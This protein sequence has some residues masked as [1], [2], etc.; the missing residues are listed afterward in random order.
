[1]KSIKPSNKHRI[2]RN[3]LFLYIRMIF[4]M[5]V[6]LYTS[7]VILRTLGFED[8]GIYDVVA[9]V[10]TMLS[11]VTASLGGASSRFITY[12]LGKDNVKESKT[13][14]ATILYIHIV[15]AIFVFIIGET[16][17][18]W[19]VY[20]KLVIPIERFE[21]SLYVYHCSIF[22]TMIHIISIPYNSLIIAYERMNIFAYI[23]IIE[24]I[25]KLVVV[26][27]LLVLP[28]DRLETYAIL[29]LIVQILIRMIYS[30]YCNKNLVISKV[31]PKKDVGLI[32]NMLSYTSWTLASGIA[33]VGYTQGLNILLNMFFGPV[34]NAARGISVQVQNAIFSFTSNIQTAMRPQIIKNFAAGNIGEMHKLVVMSSNLGFIL[35]LLL[36][37]PIIICINPILTIWLEK[38]PKHTA[39]FV[40][41]MLLSGLIEPYKVTLLNAI[42]ATGKIRKFQ[43]SE[44]IFLLLILPIS[45]I[46]LKCYNVSPEYVFLIYLIIQFITQIVRVIIILPEMDMS[47]GY[48][49]KKILLPLL[50]ISPCIVS[51]LYFIKVSNSTDFL[52]LL[53][54]IIGIEVLLIFA[55]LFLYLNNNERRMIF[56]KMKNFSRK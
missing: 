28:F 36:T 11:F 22:T 21:A 49:F 6:S 8:Y 42:H 2:M 5:S 38:V 13:V 15:L 53:I 27:F 7:R 40:I 24:V 16:I 9:G 3:T 47:F 56:D 4:V 52:G 45:Y 41:I 25:L 23:S 20:N 30:I 51:I 55:I 19:F 44:S 54:Y 33:Y 12:S 18:L 14:F 46:S 48:Y 31:K 50:K 37:I 34:V 10:I 43:I 29:L 1:M 35:I 32:K 17:G 26:F 39:N